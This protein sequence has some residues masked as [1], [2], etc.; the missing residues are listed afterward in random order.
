MLLVEEAQMAV[1]PAVDYTSKALKDRPFTENKAK[2]PFT[3]AVLCTGRSCTLVTS[4]QR[5]GV[6]SPHTNI[7]Q[8]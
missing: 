2:V 8:V 1:P 4:V 6:L 3:E 5:V 7:V